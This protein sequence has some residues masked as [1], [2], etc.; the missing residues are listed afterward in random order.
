MKILITGGL[1]YLGGRLAQHLVTK[2][3]HDVI[4]GTDKVSR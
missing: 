1:G 2:T 4:L 3:N